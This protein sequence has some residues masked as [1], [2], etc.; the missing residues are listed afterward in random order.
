MRSSKVLGIT[1]EVYDELDAMLPE[2]S[3]ET[4]PLS[5]GIDRYG[6]T[7]FNSSQMIALSHEFER[8]SL[9][10]PQ[11]RR[12]LLAALIDMCKEGALLSDCELWF[13]GD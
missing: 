2:V 9:D 8:L 11:R 13:L 1:G 7:M 4:F 10:A 5:A 3:S 12:K 6:R